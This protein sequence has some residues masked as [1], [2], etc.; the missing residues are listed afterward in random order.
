[1][2]HRAYFVI[3][4]LLLFGFILCACGGGSSNSS[5]SS[6]NPTPS[7]SA[8]PPAGGGGGSSTGGSSGG[9]SSSGGSSGGGSSSG[10]SGGGAGSSGTTAHFLYVYNSSG[11][12]IDGFDVNAS[13]GGLTPMSGSAPMDAS[14]N[15]ARFQRQDKFNTTFMYTPPANTFM[16]LLHP[17]TY[18]DFRSPLQASSLP[19]RESPRASGQIHP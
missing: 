1:M 12:T 9:G 18:S 15:L 11:K 14:P 8:P 7:A 17:E 19:F 10:G 2:S 13:N 5:T 4:A 6:N 3:G 16:G